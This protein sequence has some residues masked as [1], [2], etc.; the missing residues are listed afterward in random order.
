MKTTTRNVFTTQVCPAL[1]AIA[2]CLSAIHSASAATDTWNGTTT[3]WADAASWDNT[4]NQPPVNGDTL[5][6]GDNAGT[7]IYNN[8]GFQLQTYGITFVN[9]GYTLNGNSILISGQIL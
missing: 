2:L 9:S 3:N 4:G 6:F 8:L 5:L 7:A 1:S